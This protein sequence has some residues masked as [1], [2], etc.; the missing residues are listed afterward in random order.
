MAIMGLLGDFI[1]QNPNMFNQMQSPETTVSG[2]VNSFP[3]AGASGNRS[4]NILPGQGLAP[5]PDPSQGMNRPIRPDPFGNILP[6]QGFPPP[7]NSIQDQMFR[8]P[9]QQPVQNQMPVANSFLEQLQQ[10]AGL[11]QN[12][13]TALQPPV[14][15]NV[16]QNRFVG[17]QFQ[18]PFGMGQP[19]PLGG[20]YGS[21][22]FGYNPGTYT[23]GAFNQYGDTSTTGGINDII[24]SL[25]GPGAD[26]GGEGDAGGMF[27]G[28]QGQNDPS[29]PRNR[30]DRYDKNPD[31][32]ITQYDAST[33]LTTTYGLDD[34]GL[35]LAQKLF[36]NIAKV[37]TTASLVESAIGGLLGN[38]TDTGFSVNPNMPSN[39]LE[40]PTNNPLI[41]SY[42]QMITE[43]IPGLPV[44][45]I[46]IPEEDL[47]LGMFSPGLLDQGP[48]NEFGRTRAEQDAVNASIEQGNFVGYG[49]NEEGNFA[50]VVTG[51]PNNSPVTTG[52]TNNTSNINNPAA[53]AAI[54][55]NATPAQLGIVRP[56][57]GTS[58]GGEGSGGG[59]GRSCFVKG[60]MLQMADGTKKEISTV[61]L[62]DNTKGGIVEMTMQGLPQTIYNYKDVLVS[63]SHWVIEDNEFVAVEDSKH[64]V[65]TDKVEPVYTLKTS[66]HRMWINDIEFG[67]FETGSDNDWEPHFEMVRKKLNKEL[68]DG[69]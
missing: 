9:M 38:L 1:K 8:P 59:G 63:G 49:Q 11:L 37:P 19:T 68:R 46:N 13:V 22:G 33:G 51:G 50:G 48:T 7:L 56:A 3:D 24:N 36:G 16:P 55:A 52:F 20:N 41:A 61:E 44:S 53:V 29:N 57:I 69:K 67:D 10:S 31:G 30:Q 40:N 14:V 58:G 27:G 35:T 28:V 32:S 12:Q 15:N 6:D 43:N 65:L 5:L 26:R 54:S 66:D 39:Q 45:P 2:G 62:G 18:M 64:G 60:T 21:G 42:N 34:E 25:L 23:P 4:L 17:N 47:S